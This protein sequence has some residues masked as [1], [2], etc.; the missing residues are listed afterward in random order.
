M[1]RVFASDVLECP[2]C[3]SP[4]RVL[5]AIQSPEAIRKILDG[6]ALPSRAPP[7]APAAPRDDSPLEWA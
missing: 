1:R 2:Q 6:L 5:A 4:F 3:G 7:I